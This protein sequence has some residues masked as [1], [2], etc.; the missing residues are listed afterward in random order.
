MGW[1][2]A[3]QAGEQFQRGREIRTVYDRTLGGDVLYYTGTLRRRCHQVTESAWI[4]WATKAQCTEC[5]GSPGLVFT[6]YQFCSKAPVTDVADC[7]HHE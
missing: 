3:P 1:Q 6:H 2:D 5:S 4:E 7:A